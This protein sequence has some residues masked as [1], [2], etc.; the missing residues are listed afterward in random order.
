LAGL[1]K[2]NR[3]PD[4]PDMSKRYTVS[5]DVQKQTKGANIKVNQKATG[6]HS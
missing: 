3:K 1:E 4:M 6:V 5:Q 2:R